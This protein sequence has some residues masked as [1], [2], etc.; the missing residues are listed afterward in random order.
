[1]SIFTN[2]H[3]VV[4]V[5]VAPI[6]AIGAWYLV[7]LIGAET[8][9]AAV[10]GNNYPLVAKSN[11]RYESG[12]C[13]LENGDIEFELYIAPANTGSRLW[14]R[15][16]QSASGILVALS[17]MQFDTE[18]HAWF[19]DLPQVDG[20]SELYLVAQVDGSAYFA[21]TTTRFFTR[22]DTIPTGRD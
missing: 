15:C 9:H 2:K 8:P 18:E 22:L 4:A 14:A 12:L 19:I 13:S 20:E 10:E 6:L 16:N 3:V 7:G 5:L 17:A 21:E 11:C 1:M